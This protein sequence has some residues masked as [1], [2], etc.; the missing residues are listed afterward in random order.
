MLR[1]GELCL[2][3]PAFD[4]APDGFFFRRFSDFD[5][6]TLDRF[7]T[8]LFIPVK[9]TTSGKEVKGGSQQWRFCEKDETHF[10]FT[11]YTL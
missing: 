7:D 4:A 2:A 9:P 5:G 1:G 6:F 3:K 10:A 11:A 8:L